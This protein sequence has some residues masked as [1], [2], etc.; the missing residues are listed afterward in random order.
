VEE[1]RVIMG[2]KTSPLTFRELS[3][4][5]IDTIDLGKFT[6]HKSRIKD[7]VHLIHKSRQVDYSQRRDAL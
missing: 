4:V 5:N 3:Q 1:K 7:V 6:P 2:G